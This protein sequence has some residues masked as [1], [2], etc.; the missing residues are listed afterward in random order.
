L[1]GT[2]GT[3]DLNGSGIPSS[4]FGMPILQFGMLLMPFK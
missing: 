3:P 1:I 2:T 4:K